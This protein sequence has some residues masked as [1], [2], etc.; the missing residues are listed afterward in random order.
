[1]IHQVILKLDHY[2]MRGCLFIFIVF[3]IAISFDPSPAQPFREVAGQLNLVNLRYNNGHAVADYDQDGDLDVFMVARR[4]FSPEDPDSWSRLFSNNGDLTFTDVTSESG[5]GIQ[6]TNPGEEGNEGQKMGASWGDYNNDGYPD[7]IL[8]HYRKVELYRNNGDGSFSETTAS[9][10][11]VE[12]SEC[13]YSS[14]LW[15]DYDRDGDLD[16]YI[17]DWKE[18]NRL[19]Q[20]LGDETFKDMTAYANLGDTGNSWTSIPLDA[21]RDGFLDLYVANDFFRNKFYLNINGDYFM[22]ATSAYGLE[23]NGNGMGITVGDYNLDGLFDVYVTNIYEYEP[24]PL[25]T[26]MPGGFFYENAAEMGIE[27]AG[28]AWGTCFFDA[29]LDGDED[30]YVVNGRDFSHHTNKFFKNMW[31]EGAAEFRDWSEISL[32]DGPADAMSLSVFDLD[33]DGDLDMLVSN[34]DSSPYFYEN[35][36]IEPGKASDDNW[37]KVELEGTI[38]NRDGLGTIVK[39]TASGKSFYR[40]HHGAGL[41]SQNLVPVHF[42]LGAASAVDTLTITWPNSMQE[43]FYNI[44]SNQTVRVIEHQEMIM[45]KEG[46]VTGLKNNILNREAN[47]PRPQPNP[48]THET[49]FEFETLPGVINTLDVFSIDGTL[50]YSASGIRMPD[51]QVRIEWDGTDRKSVRLSSGIY[52]YQLNTG[53][54]LYAGKIILFR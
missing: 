50:L 13:Y 51:G 19:Y 23:D 26:A 16:L 35:R 49:I 28:W 8:T 15:W 5:F 9:S 39:A 40:Y 29:D 25:F 46:T 52:L 48:F 20:N 17:S 6:Y 47:H 18:A 42:G 53:N 12:C 41:L 44:P 3:L 7:L 33:D 2:N 31:L 54:T 1:M 37:L 27:N 22:E 38:S 36:V 43:I 24:N 11:I 34:T 4:S 14:A 45:E 32:A 10:G 21:N 30:L